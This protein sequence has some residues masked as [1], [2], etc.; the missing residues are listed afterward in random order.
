M[1]SVTMLGEHVDVVIGVDTHVET[2]TACAVRVD[3]G[4]VLDRITV[5][6]TTAG[7]RELV[8][9]ADTVCEELTGQLAR[10]AHEPSLDLEPVVLTARAWAIEGTGGHGAGLSRVLE[11]GHELVFELD[12]PQ[13][14][15]R[16]HGKKSDPLDAERAAREALSRPRLGTP[17]A[18]TGDRQVLA[19]LLSARAGAVQA[20]TDA[21]RQ[22]FSWV[23]SAP[24]QIRERLR[25][26][27]GHDLL[28]AAARL[29][30]HA[31]WGRDAQLIATTLATVARRAL[32][33]IEEAKGYDKQ[34]RDLVRQWRPDLLNQVG[35]GPIVAATVLCAWSH[36]G[37]IHSEA[38]FAMLAGA[39]PIPANSGQVA[40]RYRL[41]PY[42]DRRL[43]AAL[44]T[45]ALTRKRCHA[46]T[47][48]YYERRTAQGKSPREI[49]RCLKRYIARDLYRLLEHHQPT[50]PG[51]DAT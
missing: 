14:A 13:R 8:E 9:F 19:Q 38:A 44:H 23:V 15:R 32:T 49:R 47:Q 41:N 24:E 33:L 11:Q 6:T 42:G 22:L 46:P 16:R 45:I 34:I 21:Q 2:H 43:N 51:V 12:R 3:N 7:Y 26:R 35:V 40:H 17:R 30:G 1:T 37:R 25:G 29:R 18:G 20:A 39:A 28:T 4:A 27:R 5:P 36:P 48:A 10:A 31:T 50:S